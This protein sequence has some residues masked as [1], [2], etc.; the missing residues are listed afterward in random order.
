M[1]ESSTA[2]FRWAVVAGIFYR[3]QNALGTRSEDQPTAG[4]GIASTAKILESFILAVRC[5]VCTYKRRKSRQDCVK[6]FEQDNL[7]AVA[8][9]LSIL[10]LIFTRIDNH[11]SVYFASRFPAS[12][13]RILHCRIQIHVPPS[14]HPIH[15]THTASQPSP[16]TLG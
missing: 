6:G 1:T 12:G 5:W 14:N 8:E 2:K 15:M 11:A 13:H 4:L 3:R 7:T 10:D 9:V 16:H